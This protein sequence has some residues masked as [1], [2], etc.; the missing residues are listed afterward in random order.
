MFENE[1]ILGANLDVEVV[2][3]RKGHKVE[4]DLHVEGTIT[5]AC[6]RCLEPLTLPVS[7]GY[8]PSSE[9]ELVPTE[10][11]DGLDLSQAVY[12]TA[13]LSLP[14]KRVHP[15]GECN[16]DTVRFLAQGGRKDE[17]AAQSS[18]FSALKGLFEE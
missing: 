4:A 11:G 6:D 5:V 12:D 16:P 18:P 13:C 14:L 8:H 3:D 17:E 7:A 1:E 9:E 10:D 2:A 15:L